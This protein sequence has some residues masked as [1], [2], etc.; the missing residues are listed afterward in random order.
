[1]EAPYKAEQHRCSDKGKAVGELCGGV[2]LQVDYG[3]R[4]GR[5]GRSDYDCESKNGYKDITLTENPS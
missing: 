3:G 4:G 5:V 2:G 1:M